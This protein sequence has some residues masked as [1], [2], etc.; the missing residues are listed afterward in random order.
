MNL[1]EYMTWGVHFISY[2]DL[3]NL[4]AIALCITQLFKRSP[5]MSLA[6]LMGTDEYNALESFC[7]NLF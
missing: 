3:V 6:S 2:T 1:L 4:I 7:A 5:T